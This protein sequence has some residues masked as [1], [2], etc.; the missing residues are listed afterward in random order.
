[1]GLSQ[2]KYWNGLPFPSP[3]D[4][5][6]PGIE[7][8]SPALQADYLLLSYRESHESPHAPCENTLRSGVQG[9]EL[10]ERAPG[11]MQGSG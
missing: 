10:V 8:T 6:N 4:L 3:G 1:M 5:P 7:L 11:H 9:R 2:Q